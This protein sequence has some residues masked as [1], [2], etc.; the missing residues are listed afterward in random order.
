MRAQ[1]KLRLYYGQASYNA[2]GEIQSRNEPM[3]IQYGT[4]EYANFMKQLKTNGITDVKVEKAFDLDSVNDKEPVESANR[5]KEIEDVSKF[6]EEIKTFLAVPEKELTPEQIQI[7]KLQEQVE[8]LT[9][10]N[11]PA[12]KAAT[13]KDKE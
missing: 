5:Y 12:A 1:L 7:K 13:A 10:A 4:I 8:A 11:K 2:K 9:S 3:S 6:Q